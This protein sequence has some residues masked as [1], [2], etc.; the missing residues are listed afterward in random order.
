VFKLVAAAFLGASKSASAYLGLGAP[1][2]DPSVAPGAED[3]GGNSW[4]G[5]S[6]DANGFLQLVV[7]DSLA[8]GGFIGVREES[9]DSG[10]NGVSKIVGE[11]S[12]TEPF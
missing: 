12:L 8:S 10:A 3:T 11:G 2:R 6:G 7:K 5:G 1:S 4:G 9:A